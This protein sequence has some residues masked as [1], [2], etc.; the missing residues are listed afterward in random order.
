MYAYIKIKYSVIHAGVYTHACACTRSHTC[1][2]CI[3]LYPCQ[4][5]NILRRRS[6]ISRERRQAEKNVHRKHTAAPRDD[7]GQ[8]IRIHYMRGQIYFKMNVCL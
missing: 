1:I 6:Y 8:R 7:L 4:H 2:Q 3:P 5:T